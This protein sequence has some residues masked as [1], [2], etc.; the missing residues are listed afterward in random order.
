MP[1]IVLFQFD[2]DTGVESGSPFCVK[3]HRILAY[4]GLGYTP[5]SVRSP[6]E[7][8]RLNPNARKVPILSYDGT[9]VADSSRI[10][11]FVEQRH[12]EPPLWPED[13][14]ERSL[15]HVLEDWADESLYWYAVYQ[16]WAIDSNFKPFA[17]RTFGT[18]PPP[19]RWIVPGFVRKSVL[20]QLEGQG[21]GR[22]PLEQVQANLQQQ[23][24]MLDGLLVKQPYL[25]GEKLSAADIAVFAPLRAMSVSSMPE[26]AGIVRRRASIV[27]WLKRVDGATSSAHTVR[28]E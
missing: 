18:L 23:V 13:P 17:Q 8:K 5:R 2:G 14:Y 10:L 22:L 24:Q 9:L 27:D 25:A 3:V 1:E 21:L 20:K 11:D 15:S 7:M 26:S 19:L 16:R 12:P 4:K 28:F 6:A